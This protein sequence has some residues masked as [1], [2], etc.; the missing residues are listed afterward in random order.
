MWA[1]GPGACCGDPNPGHTDRTKSVALPGVRS[2][3][4][5]SSAQRA[6]VLQRPWKRLAWPYSPS[7]GH[8][9]LG[10]FALTGSRFCLKQRLFYLGDCFSL[11]FLLLGGLQML[12]LTLGGELFLTLQGGLSAPNTIPL[13]PKMQLRGARI[14]G[15][16][17]HS[18][19]SSAPGAPPASLGPADEIDARGA[20]PAPCV[21]GC[22]APASVTPGGSSAWISVATHSWDPL[23]PQ[24]RP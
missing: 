6:V 9:P 16:G 15:T 11:S 1:A 24:T 8:F 19:A 10:S 23:H 3:Q 18:V 4:T 13:S 20:A 21:L 22:P 17:W 14:L 12:P 5:L 7:E 2:A